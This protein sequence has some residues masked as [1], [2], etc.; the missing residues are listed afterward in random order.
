MVS[1]VTVGRDV[2]TDDL[3]EARLRHAFAA[4]DEAALEALYRDVS[5]LVYSLARRALGSETEAEDVTQQTFV[6]AWR[7]RSTFDSRRGE[8]RGWVVGIARRKIADA[9][10]ARTRDVRRLTALAAS[11]P[12]AGAAD[13]A[14]DRIDEMLLAHEIDMLGDPRRIIMALA[15]YDGITHEQIAADLNLPLGTVKSHIRRSL[16]ALRSRLEAANVAS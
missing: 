7:A 9:L 2:A 5:P 16:L 14:D 13:G 10:D 11:T 6:A 3:D 1:T 8:L 12:P 4:G 15:F